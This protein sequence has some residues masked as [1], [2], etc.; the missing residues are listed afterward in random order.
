[1]DQITP[2]P[3]WYDKLACPV[4]HGALGRDRGQFC[5]AEPACGTRFPVVEGVPVLINEA[6]S[7]F[8]AD[9]FLSKRATT[10]TERDP[11]SGVKAPSLLRRL[12]PS[13]SRSVSAASDEAFCRRYTDPDQLVLVVGAGDKTYSNSGGANLVCTDV[14]LGR[15]VSLI[16][17]AHDL[18][19]QDASMDAAVV[20]AVM[21]HV[22]DPQRCAAE[23]TRVLKPRGQVFAATPF[24]QQVHMGRYD[25][26]RFTHLGHRRLWR[27][28]RELESGISCGPG[29]ALAW[30]WQ[31]FLLSF[32]DNQ[33]TRKYLRALAKLTSFPLP[34]VDE[35]L[36]HK[37]GAYDGAS[38]F[39][40]VGEKMDKPL[41]D[42]EL[43]AGYRGLDSL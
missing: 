12:I 3:P 6:N 7:V 33:N 1:M 34:Y 40:F 39:Y 38:S 5:C 42:R 43:V 37:L 20:V 27:Y 8:T 14:H 4:C 10:F 2:S 35:L 9:D 24:M 30:A 22:A 17:D 16:A 29:M 25:F 26:T 18:P 13:N 15:N 36:Q 28:F 21:E 32:S 23:I 31:Y 19:F 11:S 41:S